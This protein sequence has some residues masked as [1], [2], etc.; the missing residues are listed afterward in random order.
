M[1]ARGIVALSTKIIVL[2]ILTGIVIVI[3]PK[4]TILASLASGLAENQSIINQAESSKVPFF[5]GTHGQNASG[6]GAYSA[7]VYIDS[8]I[9]YAKDSAGTMIASCVAGTDDSRV[10]QAAITAAPT[11]GEVLIKSGTYLLNA[12]LKP[13]AD[14]L[15]LTGEGNNTILKLKDNTVTTMWVPIIE[16]R[17]PGPDI[18]NNSSRVNIVVS[19][20]AIDG[21]K[22]N[23][24]PSTNVARFATL[25][26]WLESGKPQRP[27]G[28][29]LRNLSVHDCW[30][31]G[32]YL[33]NE[34]EA[35]PY[36]PVNVL[37]ENISTFNNGV[38]GSLP[39]YGRSGIHLDAVRNVTLNNIFSHNNV[40]SGIYVNSCTNIIGKNIITYSNGNSI[41]TTKGGGLYIGVAGGNSYDCMFSLISYDDYDGVHMIGT[42]EES[43]V[44]RGIYNCT[45]NAT[46]IDA[47]HNG[48]YA[49][50]V[51]NSSIHGNCFGCV[52]DGILVPTAK[53]LKISGSYISNGLAGV[54]LNS[55][56]NE[57]EI[58]NVIAMNNN[59]NG[60][61]LYGN[62][63]KLNRIIIGNNSR[64]RAGAYPDILNN[65]SNNIFE[66]VKTISSTAENPKIQKNDYIF[67]AIKELISKLNWNN[68]LLINEEA[69]Q[70]DQSNE[71]FFQS[72]ISG[73]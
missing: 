6:K 57:C 67:S 63:N 47:L 3:E 20:L 31:G 61:R 18:I 34:L 33:E 11:S 62:Y 40:G 39:G 26:I 35:A 15:Y 24:A 55:D 42:I 49:S 46:I 43:A 48:I 37:L 36:L 51:Y 25:G 21:N 2:L 30:S 16:I 29:V 68:L 32:I 9:L 65:G 28:Y 19:N 17:P 54:T 23:Q 38:D 27:F 58:E 64:G 59:E 73:R 71:A 72:F 41:F 8:G 4:S 14:G 22:V 66:D 44:K 12:S 7:I 69:R 56:A 1:R 5:A 53:R 45:I 52:N 50:Y 60:I 70:I 13:S 10:I